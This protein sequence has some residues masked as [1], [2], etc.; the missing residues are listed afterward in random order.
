MTDL[1][2]TEVARHNSR[3]S[4]HRQQG[5]KRWEVLLALAISAAIALVVGVMVTKRIGSAMNEQVDNDFRRISMALH[6]YKLDNNRYPST[7][8]GLIALFEKPT[9]APLAPLWRS[10]YINRQTLIYDPWNNT[11]LYESSAAPPGFIVS[12][13][14]ADGVSG[15]E[16]LNEDKILRFQSDENYFD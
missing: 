9:T 16:E 3:M 10:P 12:T 6:Q 13:L 4:R 7:E 5:I 15:G 1:H 14:G 8:Q 2:Y 11:Y